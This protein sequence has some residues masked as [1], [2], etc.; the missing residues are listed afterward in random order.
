MR[1]SIA[2]STF[3]SLLIYI[4]GPLLLLFIL[5]SGTSIPNGSCYAIAESLKAQKAGSQQCKTDTC[6]I[7][8]K[9]KR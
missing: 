5:I 3:P 7:F 6:I 8:D 9:S 2:Y 1:W 4:L